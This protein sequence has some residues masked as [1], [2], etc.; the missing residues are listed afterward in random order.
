MLTNSSTSVRRVFY[1][2]LLVALLAGCAK[3]PIITTPQSDGEVSGIANVTALRKQLAVPADT[4]KII[5]IH[6]MSAH[7]PG[8]SLTD[9]LTPENASAF[10]LRRKAGDETRTDVLFNAESAKHGDIDLESKVTLTR[11]MFTS[12][13]DGKEVELS[14]ITWSQLGQWLKVTQ[15]H[16]DASRQTV[17]G[18]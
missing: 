14:E 17:Y 1:A 18:C 7:C 11:M 16:E 6:G 4:I 8:Y 5:L 12:I 10:G 9:W 3:Y 2:S 15:L 13:P